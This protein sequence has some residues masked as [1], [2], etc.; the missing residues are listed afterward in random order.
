M[1]VRIVWSTEVYLEGDNMKEI[2][3]KWEHLSLYSKDLSDNN[4]EYVEICSVEDGETYN[5]LQ[6]EFDNI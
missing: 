5:D 3:D 1:K 2:K 6:N 4:A